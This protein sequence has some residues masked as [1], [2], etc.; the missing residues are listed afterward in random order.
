M[1]SQAAR[2]AG[3]TRLAASRPAAG[4]A[5]FRTAGAIALCGFLQCAY[6]QAEKGGA[7]VTGAEPPPQAEN[8][9][10]PETFDTLHVCA[11]PSGLPQ[12]NDR[13]EG[14]ENKIAQALAHDLGKKIDY[15]YFPQRMGFV[16]N[17]LR[18]RDETT[19]KYKCDV[20]IGVPKG[21][22]L[23]ATT[24]PY[25][26]S[27]YALVFKDRPD[28]KSVKSPQDFLALPRTKLQSLHI[29]IFGYS[30]AVNWLL[31]NGLIERAQVYPPQSGDPKET[32]G[33]VVARDLSADKIDAAVVW[34]PYAGAMLAEHKDWVAV[35]F[36]SAQKIRFDYEISMGVRFGEEKWKNTLDQW[37]GT[38][39]AQIDAILSSYHIP[40]LPTT[41]DAPAS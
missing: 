22:E 34:G 30:P 16:R 31:D 14:Y 38:H 21:Y 23:T 25:M 12:S 28:L 32:P 37:I 10:G 5:F 7:T 24:K 4:R 6:A 36:K 26:H 40:L 8:E 13:G 11:D 15:T 9:P 39:Q 2:V 17:T 18:S 27:T 19:L 20:I 1:R 41:P 35:P 3:V 33:S 29:G